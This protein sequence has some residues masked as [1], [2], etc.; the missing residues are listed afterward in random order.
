MKK[1]AVMI[2]MALSLMVSG[3]NANILYVYGK[4][5]TVTGV[6]PL[7]KVGDAAYFRIV[8]SP[9]FAVSNATV[10]VNDSMLNLA[11]TNDG[12]TVFID[13]N[14]A[15]GTVQWSLSNSPV[16]SID[17]ASNTPGGVIPC[18][19]NFDLGRTFQIF[20]NGIIANG[21]VT[22]KPVTRTGN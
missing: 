14:P 21:T 1:T 9:T 18:I 20:F 5:D 3:V 4:V 15:D 22:S 2:A 6:N 11:R 8:Y 7:I 19:D 17:V 13:E 16:I 10:T 12:S